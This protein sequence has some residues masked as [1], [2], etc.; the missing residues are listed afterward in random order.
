MKKNQNFGKNVL[1]FGRTGRANR[2]DAAKKHYEL[3]VDLGF[4]RELD[5]RFAKWADRP[6][7]QAPE[8]TEA[9]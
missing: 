2:I 4:L 8:N 3:G 7:L 1:G 9:L 6:T 5:V